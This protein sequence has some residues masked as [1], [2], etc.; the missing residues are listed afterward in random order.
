MGSQ[1]LEILRQG[2]WASFTGGWFYDPRQDHESNILH[3]YL[4]LFLL[5][6]P[7]SLYMFL[8]PTMPVWLCYAGVVGVLFATLKIINVRLHQMFD[9]GECIEES[10]DDSNRSVSVDHTGQGSQAHGSK[11]ESEHIEMAV[12][13]Q[14]QDE[15]TPPVQCSSR[16]SFTDGAVQSQITNG[17]VAPTSSMELLGRLAHSDDF[18]MKSHGVCGIDLQ[19]DVHHR[20][21][22]GSSGGSVSGKQERSF[23][24]TTSTTA[25][26]AS[27]EFGLVDEVLKEV[28]DLKAGAVSM[29]PAPVGL[30]TGDE[31]AVA[32][33]SSTSL[34]PDSH[35]RSQHR[36]RSG[37]GFLSS[38]SSSGSLRN[39]TGSV[40]LAFLSQDPSVRA[41]EL[42]RAAQQRKSSHALRGNVEDADG[43]WLVRRAHS[44]LETSAAEKQRAAVPPSH[45]VSLE[46]IRVGSSTAAP[47][48]NVRHVRRS[49]EFSRPP[50]ATNDSSA[51]RTIA[52]QPA[53]ETPASASSGSSSVKSLVRHRSLDAATLR[54]RRGRGEKKKEEESG[55]VA[56]GNAESAGGDRCFPSTDSVS[57]ASG[58]S[59]RSSSHFTVIYKPLDPCSGNPQ[60]L[61]LPEQYPGWLEGNPRNPDPLPSPACSERSSVAGLDWLFS[62]ASVQPANET[63]VLTP[64]EFC[65]EQTELN[66]CNH[67]RAGGD[68][69]ETCLIAT[70]GGDADS[71][72]LPWQC[73][74]SVARAR[75]GSSE[76]SLSDGSSPSSPDEMT[77]LGAS[78]RLSTALGAIPKQYIEDARGDQSY[79]PVPGSFTRTT[80]R[81]LLSRRL[82]EIL[83]LN[84]P[85]ECEA[86]LQKLK[87]EL[88]ICRRLASNAEEVPASFSPPSSKAPA[89]NRKRPKLAATRRKANYGTSEFLSLLPN[90]PALTQAEG[91]KD[92]ESAVAVAGWTPSGR[93]SCTDRGPPAYLLASI[94]ST[95]GTHLAISHDDTSPGAVHCFQDEHGNW[96][97]YTFDE[98]S[99]GV[100]RGLEMSPD[101]KIF[102]MMFDSKWETSSHSSSSSSSSATMLDSGSP[103]PAHGTCPI[104]L[105]FSPAPGM[106]P[107][108]T[109]EA[110]ASSAAVATKLRPSSHQQSHHH[111]S[112]HHHAHHQQQQQPHQQQ[113]QQ[114]PSSSSA[115]PHQYAHQPRHHHHHHRRSH[116]SSG[117]HGQEAAA[118][119]TLDLSLPSGAGAGLSLRRGATVVL[120]NRYELIGGAI[121]GGGASRF[122][123]SRGAVP[124]LLAESLLS[125]MAMAAA[126]SGVGGAAT[127]S[128]TASSQD[129]EL[130]STCHMR[131]VGSGTL[132]GSK[133]R[134]YY[135]FRLLPCK[136]IKV[137]FDRLALITVLDRNLTAMENILSVVLAVLVAILGALCLSRGFFQDIYSFLFCFVMASCQYC[138]LKSV[139][140]DAAS[141]TH[142][143]NRVV[144]YSRPVYFCLCC[145]MLMLVQFLIDSRVEYPHVTLYGV[146]LVTDAAVTWARSFLIVFILAFPVTFSLGLLPQINTFVTYLLEQIDMNLFGGSATTGLVSAVYCISR[147]LAFVVFLFG[148]AYVA[149]KEG[150]NPSQHIMFSLFCG[151]LVTSCYLL[152]RSASDPTILWNL[153][154]RHL[155][156]ENAPTAN[157][158]DS[159][160]EYVDPLPAKLE[161]TFRA[162][163]R[164]DAIHCVFVAIFVFAV[165]VSTMFSALQPYLEML[166]H[167]TAVVWGLLLHY[168][169]PQ[170]RKQLPW[171]CCA[172]PILKSSEHQQ[173]EVREP[174]R[175]MWFEKLQVWMWFIE[176]N[177]IY[178]LLF[179]SAL[180]TSTP[181]IIGRFGVA[182]GCLVLVVC[183]LKCLRSAFNDPSQHFLVLLFTTLFFSYDYRGP[184][185]P[186]LINYFCCLFVFSKVYELLLK[187]SFIITYIAPWQITWGSAFHAFAQ[188]FS[189]PHSAMLFV[190][191]IISAILST[192]LSPVLGSAI[193]FTSYVRPVK[194]WERDYNTKRVD[195]SNTRLSSQLERNPGSDDNNLNSI[196][197]EHLTRSLQQSL[198]GDLA[199]GRWGNVTQGDCFVLASDNLNCLLHIIELANGLVTFQLRGLEFRGTYCQQREV[200]AISEGVEED[201][202]CCC[203][204]PGRLPHLLSPNAAFGQRWLAWQV[205][206]ARYVLEGY[207]ISDNSAVSMLQVFELRKALVTYYVKAIVYYTVTS[208]HLEEWLALPAV[209][210]ALHP[211]LDRN[212]TD[213]DPVFNMNIDEDYDFRA[214]GISR[215]SFCNVYLDWLQF[216][217]A[218][219][220]KNLEHD[221]NSVV[222]SLCF[223]LSLLARRALGTASHN[224]FS[225]SVDLLLYGLHALFKG[226]FRITC[227]RDEW[228]FQDMELLRRVVAP[229]VRMALKLHQDHFLSAE[230]DDHATLYEAISNYEKN[231]VISHEADPAWRNAVLSSVPS[232]LAL[233]H[234]FD[235]S[236][237]DYKIIMLNKRQLS[238]RVIKVNRECVRGLWAGQQQELVYL[239][240]R[241][242]E[243]GS[244]QNARQALRNII[245]S[246]CDQPIGYPIYVSPLTTSFLET[247]EQLCG[248]IGGPLSLSRFGGA[249]LGFWNR[250]KI[251]CGEGCS[252]GG[253]AIQDDAIFDY[254]M[255]GSL[256]GSISRARRSHSSGSHSVSHS[257]TETGSSNG[258]GNSGGIGAGLDQGSRSI[259]RTS[260]SS[261][262]GRGSTLSSLGR[263]STSFT[264]TSLNN[265]TVSSSLVYKVSGTPGGG[266]TILGT[267]P[268]RQQPCVAESSL[269]APSGPFLVDV[270]RRSSASAVPLYS[271]SI[272]ANVPSLAANLSSLVSVAGSS[273]GV[274]G[275]IATTTSSALW[276]TATVTGVPSTE[277]VNI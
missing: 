247:S 146:R 20:N 55:A 164:T 206:A 213:V 12:L 221:R 60:E 18:E 135:R 58:D 218:R 96:Q 19:V 54:Q 245:N 192:P 227:V 271:G 228:V 6:L 217:V 103:A 36:R 153:I 239:R 109:F 235:D 104:T 136:S 141:P 166:L 209:R 240:N 46:A 5:C 128:Q 180:S 95:P 22:S 255:A 246:S 257:A 89:S 98:N 64:L 25:G 59:D 125:R 114:L 147:S 34:H 23:H 261:S 120:E 144:L 266:T 219:S 276:E 111:R 143:Y 190:Q 202:G 169:L 175:V 269:T 27:P 212:Y 174:A 242:P 52:E 24:G 81:S 204:E 189:V 28:S 100:S 45:P 249:L 117:Q 176:K 3:L 85:Q 113:L 38:G 241:N 254:T 26:P 14:R 138:L 270:V 205:A 277:K 88:D 238:F 244:I 99:T 220:G 179:L 69:T 51:I 196:F 243:R 186:F 40:E 191:A 162:R 259:G 94:L 184:K 134:H 112:H 263:N 248:L 210:D 272:A 71:A 171:L 121:E 93:R 185:E 225:S 42:A 215:S 49:V 97:T 208:S 197:Y 126:S 265:L 268:S 70:A 11:K 92:E 21:S 181:D 167:G 115:T 122:D 188:P 35:R 231:L 234:V 39:A 63:K 33:G 13:K 2:V 79:P 110:S 260:A 236:S 82:L 187:I 129:T 199:L 157:A 194:F 145:S 251:R 127:L 161:K 275:G 119:S 264:R 274:S 87:R 116:H 105:G 43:N 148:L 7:F 200:E 172:H 44:E 137:G 160:P 90:N 108:V 250:L 214:S 29:L 183:G 201:E 223:S 252:S 48:S 91:E 230:Y 17:A 195:H 61:D 41:A 159:A 173:F 106:T 155:W 78:G 163:L 168:C 132:R 165:H 211:T 56:S 154:K 124:A 4:W 133:P 233:R 50:L 68:T 253:T 15:E 84:D 142:G 178:P 53:A 229:S 72:L 47:A 1:T 152:S 31:L 262:I 123:T 203:C 149:L 107:C 65:K 139:Q 62:G 118:P 37:T 130:D 156:A 75:S 80:V 32:S 182:G 66:K 193:F 151:F 67:P 77:P 83:N 73:E 198:Y 256:S 140:P 267:T 8:Q 216:C 30:S 131:F 258:G 177:L 237:D 150:H 222:V 224:S 74:D 207:S 170:L 9:S 232:L 226:D 101:T 10:S 273:G 102:Q 86:E 76:Q 16:N 158:T 57:S